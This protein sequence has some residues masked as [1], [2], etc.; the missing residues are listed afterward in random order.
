MPSEILTAAWNRPSILRSPTSFV[1][2]N[3]GLIKKNV[4]G[5]TAPAE[6]AI[7]VKEE[8]N[9]CGFIAGLAG[10]L[11]SCIISGII[12]GSLEKSL[13]TGIAA[14]LALSTLVLTIKAFHL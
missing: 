12:V 6:R 1:D 3:P 7:F 14:T 4:V 9:R 2:L 8:L 13:E 5:S 10:V 11:L